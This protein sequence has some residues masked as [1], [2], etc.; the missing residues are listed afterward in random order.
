MHNTNTRWCIDEHSVYRWRVDRTEVMLR[1]EAIASD[2]ISEDT[3][4]LRSL[5]GTCATVNYP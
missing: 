1:S 4:A 5:I 2:R 3:R